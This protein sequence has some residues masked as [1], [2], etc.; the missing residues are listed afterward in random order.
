MSAIYHPQGNSTVERFN[1]VFKG[2]LQTARLENTNR[3]RAVREF[4]CIYRSTPH[5]TTGE[6]PK[7]A[8]HG[9]HL[10]TK[11]DIVGATPVPTQTDPDRVRERVEHAQTKSKQY[12][13][14][15]KRVKHRVFKVHDWVRVHLPGHIPKGKSS[16]SDPLQITKKVGQSTYILSDGKTWNVERLVPYMGGWA[17]NQGRNEEWLL[18]VAGQVEP[19][20]RP[21]GREA[22]RERPIRNRRPPT[23]VR[24]YVMD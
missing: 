3:K 12:F 5:A 14:K 11:L 13:D 22:I 4:L 2:Y 9:R 18:P 16:Y 6:S 8:L 15:R 10:R 17:P 23:W 7:M 19:C 21:R 20:E 1:R 24:D